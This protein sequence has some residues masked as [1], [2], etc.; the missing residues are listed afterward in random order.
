M[1]LDNE[2]QIMEMCRFS[3]ATIRVTA[4]EINWVGEGVENPVITKD[5]KVDKQNMS[6]FEFFAIM[7]STVIG[8]ER[9]DEKDVYEI[10]DDEL[11]HE[12]F[13]DMCKIFVYGTKKLQ[14]PVFISDFYKYTSY[15]VFINKWQ[16][17]EKDIYSIRNKVFNCCSGT[18]FSFVFC[19][20]VLNYFLE[21]YI[22]I[23]PAFNIRDTNIAD[24][25]C[26]K[27]LEK[28]DTRDLAGCPIFNTRLRVLRKFMFDNVVIVKLM[29]TGRPFGL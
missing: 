25:M 14:D 4:K 9:K 2:I 5:Y 27:I 23:V 16:G 3:N 13:E 7:F 24:N 26:K 12:V 10:K 8:Q 17:S 29:T 21:T 11:S 22:K 6:K 15:C 28:V 19:V 18:N 1:S 20:N